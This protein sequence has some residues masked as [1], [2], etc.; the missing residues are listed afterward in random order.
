MFCSLGRRRLVC[1]GRTAPRRTAPTHFFVPGCDRTCFL[2][3]LTSVPQ[4][5]SFW[6]VCVLIFLLAPTHCPHVTLTFLLM[7]SVLMCIPSPCAVA[8][9]TGPSC[10]I[11]PTTL[12]KKPTMH[13]RVQ[14]VVVVKGGN[15]TRDPPA[16][17]AEERPP[18]PPV[19]ALVFNACTHRGTLSTLVVKSLH[20]PRRQEFACTDRARPPSSSR[21]CMHR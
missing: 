8:A 1:G 5:M 21:V 9:G 10:I 4:R 11:S 20:T 6:A 13:R 15:S 3:L 12:P 16:E 18:P 17:Q 19:S 7:P 14:A 2:R